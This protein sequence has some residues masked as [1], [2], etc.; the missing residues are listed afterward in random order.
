MTPS[1]RAFLEKYAAQWSRRSEARRLSGTVVDGRVA[2]TL[3]GIVG[4]LLAELADAPA[5]EELAPLVIVACPDKITWKSPVF[6]VGGRFNP[7]AGTKREGWL[8]SADACDRLGYHDVA[9]SYRQMAADVDP[10]AYPE[11][12]QVTPS[13][14]SVPSPSR[15]P[16][17]RR[18]TWEG[19][20]MPPGEPAPFVAGE[21]IG[22]QL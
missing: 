11:A 21:Q 10:D 13:A 18:S 19:L 16:S 2:D 20:P 15:S 3:D 12:V 22:F 8:A 17:R 14:A 9:A 5:E 4:Q 7:F 6:N 1:R